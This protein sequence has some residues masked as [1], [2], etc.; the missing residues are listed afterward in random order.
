MKISKSVFVV[1]ILLFCA[2]LYW[3]IAHDSRRQ[4]IFSLPVVASYVDEL[5]RF[6]KCACVCVCVCFVVDVVF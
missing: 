1:L 4:R 2:A 6:E 5:K 3:W